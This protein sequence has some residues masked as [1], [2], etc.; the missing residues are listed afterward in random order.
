[1]KRLFASFLLALASLTT[2]DSVSAQGSNWQYEATVYLFMPES[3][4]AITT[5]AGRIEGT[6]SFSDALDNLDFAFMGAFGASN[7]QWSFLI[8]YMY[9]DLSFGNATPGP[10]HSGL[11][12]SMTTKILNGY[13]G[14]RV[15]DSG[16]AQVDIAGGFRWF[17]TN[18]ALT[19]LPGTQPQRTAVADASW[20]DPVIGVR[21]RVDFSERWQGTAFVDYGGFSSDNET[22]QVLLTADYE[23][24]DNWM[25][26]GGYR[27]ISM[28][29]IVNGNPFE[30][31]QSGPIFGATYRF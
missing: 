11:N 6:L 21:A 20:V 30:F 9:N 1:M 18:T 25:L 3:K 31:S 15:Y 22:W 16:S 23:L 4:T 27:Y 10:A 12:T 28:E 13:V 19:L 2:T 17:D 7:G 8:D 5:P 29:N 24:N 14:Y 26:R